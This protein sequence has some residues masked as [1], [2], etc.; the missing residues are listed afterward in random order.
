M[1]AAKALN[2]VGAEY[3]HI[4]I[5]SSSTGF[6][7]P[8]FW[9]EASDDGLNDADEIKESAKS[10]LIL[11]K[12]LNTT[13]ISNDI[14]K[15]M[16]DNIYGYPFYC[17]NCPRNETSS[18]LAVYL[19]DN[20][21]TYLDCLNKTYLKYGASQLKNATAIMEN[22]EGS[23]DM[24]SVIGNTFTMSNGIRAAKY[25]ITGLDTNGNSIQFAS[26]DSN[27]GDGVV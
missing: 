1:R 3:V 12:F 16:H 5:Q 6:G 27:S 11:D 14:L 10:V 20:M 24:P 4:F 25:S 8:P 22:L 19:A 9:Q 17:T 23:K 26:I 2:M 7:D 21:L 18:N 13:E 15:E